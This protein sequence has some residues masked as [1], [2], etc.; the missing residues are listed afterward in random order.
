MVLSSKVKEYLL[1]NNLHMEIVYITTYLVNE[2]RG[3]VGFTSKFSITM[4]H[5]CR[6]ISCFISF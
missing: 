1:T 4:L 2:H 5:K 3:F 6:G